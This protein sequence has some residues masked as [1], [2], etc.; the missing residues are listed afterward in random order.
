[1]Y[2]IRLAFFA[3][4]LL[5]GMPAAQSKENIDFSV[6]ITP[7]LDSYTHNLPVTITLKN[8]GKKSIYIYNDLDYLIYSFAQASSGKKLRRNFIEEVLPPP[9]QKDSFVLLQPGDIIQHTRNLTPDDLGI[10]QRGKYKITFLYD[11]YFP[12]NVTDG[13]RVW[14]GQLTTSCDIEILN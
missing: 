1:M 12:P 2:W 11:S 3:I 9:P 10:S 6:K 5:L 8:I 4:S 13:L 14:D 7:V